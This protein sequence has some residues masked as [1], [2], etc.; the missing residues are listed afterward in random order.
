MALILRPCFDDLTRQEI[1]QHIEQ[2]R[3]RRMVAAMEYQAGKTLALS[4]ESEKV[5]R[6]IKQQ[7]ELLGKEILQLDKLDE[8][9]D[10][11]MTTIETL[12]QEFNL[13]EEMQ[14]AGQ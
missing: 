1:E 11:R 6:R 2:V 8:R 7:Y 10:K 13:I 5:Q 3:S 4:Q 14:E 12:R 9:I